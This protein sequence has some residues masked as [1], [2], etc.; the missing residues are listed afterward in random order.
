MRF[1]FLLIL[2]CLASFKVKAQQDS[3]KKATVTLAALYSSNVSYYGQATDER[4]PYVLINATVRFPVGF[5][6]SAGSYKLLNYGSG[7]SET[8]IGAGFDYD[9]NDKLTAGLS[10]TR[11]FFPANSPL[12]QAANEN[13]AN[14]SLKYE[15]PWLKSS[16]STDY[17][18]GKENDVF[19]SLSHSKEIGI[20]SLINEKNSLSLE[21]AIE[22]VAG[23]RHFYETYTVEKSNRGKGKSPVSPG[24]SNSTT[25][26]TVA[27]NNFN[28]LS[29]NF[30]LPLSLSRANYM[31]ELSYQLSVL[32]SKSE[33]ELK[34]QQSFFGLAFYYQF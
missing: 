24:N 26:T 4:L 1:T 15:W 11:S 33:A 17:A 2:I 27:S 9:F 16:L 5:Y 23:T 34:P 13:N 7:I 25:T 6:L 20:G 31:A 21:P 12:L 29:Y 19:I 30:K 22:L 28:L 14:V 32:G 10:Y 8:D 18:F 3:V